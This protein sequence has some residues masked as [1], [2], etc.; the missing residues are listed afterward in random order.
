MKPSFKALLPFAVFFII[1]IM[2]HIL[3]QAENVVR[4]NFSLYAACVAI[5]SSFFTFQKNESLNEKIDIF[6]QGSTQTIVIHMCFIFYIST[7][8][9]ALLEQTGG[10][11]S[12]VNLCLTFV[13]TWAVLPGVFV[14]T[15][16]FSFTIGTSMGAIAAFMPI[17][18][19]IA[20][21]STINPSMMA[22]TIVCGA[23]F[24][25]NL[26]IL[27]DTTIAAV[28]ITKSSMK[29]KL[30]LNTK[31]ALPAFICSLIVLFYQNQ[32][33]CSTLQALP[34]ATIGLCDVIKII[35]Y[36]AVF[37]FALA[38][39]D[40]LATLTLGTI[41]TMG[42]GLLLGN[43]TLLQ[44]IN[45]MFDGFYTSKPMVN[46]FILVLFLSGLSKIITHNGG[47][48]YLI[49]TL[50]NQISQRYASI[51]IVL[52]ITLINMTIAINTIAI[53]LTGPVA[54]N[55]GEKYKIHPSETACILD[56]GS[57]ISQ[58]LLPYGPQ[59]LLA[60]SMAHV[61]PVSLFAYLYYQYFLAL[62]LLLM[63]IFK[64]QKAFY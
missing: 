54:I 14:V 43:I 28:S 62:A 47:I 63:I 31:I 10:I 12:A 37:Y 8:F 35:P 17:A 13:P 36:G 49:Q 34:H 3:Y 11:A 39:M 9:T 42:I 32:L 5:I 50:E 55:I 1:F 45:L 6:I 15:S 46:I 58:G 57:C 30:R 2:L 16:L 38:G 41:L 59:I 56:I 60:A 24:G 26:S 19:H 4:D 53:L 51:I 27:S 22:A 18:T 44:T 33:V 40:I 25:D 21:H 29:D 48:E 23:M 7:V 61:S 52:L 64:P 20:T